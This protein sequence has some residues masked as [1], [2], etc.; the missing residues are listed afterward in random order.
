MA[1]QGKN[2]NAKQG[3]SMEQYRARRRGSD[4]V[5]TPGEWFDVMDGWDPVEVKSTQRRINTGEDTVSAPRNGRWRLWHSQHEKMVEQGGEYDLVVID[6]GEIWRETTLSAEEVSDVIT[7]N[8]LKWTGGG[9]HGMSSEQVKIPW[10]YV[11]E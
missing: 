5:H 2:Q 4:A 3:E 6:D 1:S 11:F 9:G 7:E 8:E 10:H